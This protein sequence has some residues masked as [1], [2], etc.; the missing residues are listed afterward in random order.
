MKIAKAPMIEPIKVPIETE[1]LLDDDET[2]PADGLVVGL[3]VPEVATMLEPGTRAGA[4][5]PIDVGAAPLK[6]KLVPVLVPVAVAPPDIPDIVGR[7]GGAPFCRLCCRTLLV[8][9]MATG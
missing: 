3:D 5:E 1:L 9:R 8:M 2:A 4:F 7:G 6:S